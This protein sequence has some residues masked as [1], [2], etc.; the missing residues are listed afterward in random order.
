MPA[1]AKATSPCHA[2]KYRT[3]LASPLVTVVAVAVAA[4][5][6]TVLVLLLLIVSSFIFVDDFLIRPQS[7]S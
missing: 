5:S 3:T 4:N 7:M 2:L 6:N 1:T